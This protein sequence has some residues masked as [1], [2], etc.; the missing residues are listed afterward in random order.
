MPIHHDKA[1]YGKLVS[2]QETLSDDD[3]IAMAQTLSEEDDQKSKKTV[4]KGGLEQKDE[5]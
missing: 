4:G 1:A 3:L 2:L 5:K